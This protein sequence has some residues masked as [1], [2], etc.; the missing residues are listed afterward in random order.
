[1]KDR[2]FVLKRTVKKG[3]DWVKVAY[4]SF[5]DDKRFPLCKGCIRSV[6]DS[7][8]WMFTRTEGGFKIDLQAFLDPRGSLNPMIVNFIQ[9]TW[10]KKSITRLVRVSKERK[11]VIDAEWKGWA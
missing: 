4:K 1:M 10:P 8:T 3:R 9:S 2:Q 5:E 7:T 6:T 11:G